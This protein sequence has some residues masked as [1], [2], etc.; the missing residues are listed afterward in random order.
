[1]SQRMTLAGASEARNNLLYERSPADV[2]RYLVSRQCAGFC[3]PVTGS[4]A[5]VLSLYEAHMSAL[6]I[7]S[8]AR[9]RPVVQISESRPGHFASLRRF[10]TGLAAKREI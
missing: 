8:Q 10:F 5:V 1:M 9:K 3:W 2:A 7:L 4:N 6:A